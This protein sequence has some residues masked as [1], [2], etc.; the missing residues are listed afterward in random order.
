M[1]LLYNTHRPPELLH[2]LRNLY[3]K[4]DQAPAVVQTVHTVSDGGGDGNGNGDPDDHG[5]QVGTVFQWHMRA[6]WHFDDGDMPDDGTEFTF[7]PKL[8]QIKRPYTHLELHFA[9]LQAVGLD[10]YVEWF[11]RGSERFYLW[12]RATSG[13]GAGGHWNLETG[14]ANHY[15]LDGSYGYNLVP[16][17]VGRYRIEPHYDDVIL[18]NGD[19]AF[20]PI[21]PVRLVNPSYEWEK[22]KLLARIR[23]GSGHLGGFCYKAWIVGRYILRGMES[24]PEQHVCFW[25][26]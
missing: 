22:L 2:E 9:V 11:V 23:V 3:R 25:Q 21:F 6:E 13:E 14:V 24:E 4:V 7:T 1:P 5:G 12:D 8:P 20:T 16:F 17:A 19:L 18:P 10:A 26:E 15:R